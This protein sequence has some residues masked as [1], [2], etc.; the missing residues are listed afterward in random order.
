VDVKNQQFEFSTNVTN[1]GAGQQHA[2]AGFKFWRKKVEK[3]VLNS[4]N[5]LGTKYLEEHRNWDAL[6]SCPAISLL[7]NFKLYIIYICLTWFLLKN[8][9][10]SVSVTVSLSLTLSFL[11]FLVLNCEFCTG[12]IL[13]PLLTSGLDSNPFFLFLLKNKALVYIIITFIIY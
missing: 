5:V 3:R 11:I 12:H 9:S 8:I 2:E 7:L 4:R 1:P 10:L 13:F 6:F